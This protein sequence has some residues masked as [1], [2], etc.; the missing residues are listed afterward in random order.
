MIPLTAFTKEQLLAI[1]Y[2]LVHYQCDGHAACETDL[3][4]DIEDC[5]LVVTTGLDEH[6]ECAEITAITL[7]TKK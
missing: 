1:I 5:K 7:D 3:L 4:Q 6:P 2:Y